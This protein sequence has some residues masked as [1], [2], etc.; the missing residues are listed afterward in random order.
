MKL[1]IV[2]LDAIRIII[3]VKLCGIQTN[4][5]KIY[6]SAHKALVDRCTTL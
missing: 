4:T 5:N 3:L 2:V 1:I 6:A